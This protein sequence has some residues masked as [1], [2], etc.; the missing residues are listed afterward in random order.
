VT[1]GDAVLV[2]ALGEGVS[3]VGHAR[4]GPGAF[5]IFFFFISFDFFSL[6]LKFKFEFKPCCD[7]VL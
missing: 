1:S 2:R 5:F 3:W 6:Y 7:L 4:I